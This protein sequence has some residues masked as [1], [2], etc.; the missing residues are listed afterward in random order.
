MK[1]VLVATV[2]LILMLHSPLARAQEA[3]LPE[4]VMLVANVL[5]LDESQ[6]QALVKMIQDRDAAIRPLAETLQAQH[7]ALAALIETP[8]ADPAKV[9]QALIDIH[10]GEK[11]VSQIAQAAAATFAATLTD[12]QR[13]RMQAV[14]QAAQ[15]APAV[16]AFKAVGL[17]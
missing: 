11:Q 17:I 1:K 7:A 8:N 3:T 13:Q 4:P 14:I 2:S 16:P 9:G 10:N 12:D 15:I 6:V 5:Q